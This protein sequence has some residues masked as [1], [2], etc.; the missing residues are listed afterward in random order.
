MSKYKDYFKDTLE[1]AVT[2]YL[3]EN[4]SKKGSEED[5]GYSDKDVDKAFK[6]VKEEFL[7]IIN[8]LN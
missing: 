2:E 4:C 6:T 1:E 7:E 8:N 5:Y 3:Q